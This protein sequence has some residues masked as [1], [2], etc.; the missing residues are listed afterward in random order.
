MGEAL[1]IVSENDGLVNCDIGLV[2]AETGEIIELDDDDKPIRAGR[3]PAWFKGIKKGF[4]S[5][6]VMKLGLIDYMVLVEIMGRLKYGNRITINQTRLANDLGCSRCSV[7]RSLAV[8]EKH[9][10]ITR[11]ER[12]SKGMSEYRLNP[13][14]CWCGMAKNGSK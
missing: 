2:D 14:Y 5:V 10:I 8:L 6:K 12:N 11:Q 7:N 3:D 13:A 9:V 1:R 4:R